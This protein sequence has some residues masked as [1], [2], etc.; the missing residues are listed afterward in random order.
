MPRM[1]QR[2]PSFSYRALRSPRAT[3]STRGDPAAS[4]VARWGDVGPELVPIAGSLTRASP[5]SERIA[6]GAAGVPGRPSRQRSG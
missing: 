4:R 6:A 3:H 2:S 5:T 1:K